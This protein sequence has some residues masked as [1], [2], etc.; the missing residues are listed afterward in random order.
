MGYL[1]DAVLNHRTDDPMAVEL[2]ELMFQ[3]LQS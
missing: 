3:G 1:K 2:I